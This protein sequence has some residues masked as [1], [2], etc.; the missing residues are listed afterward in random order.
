[1]DTLREAIDPSTRV[2]FAF[3]AF[4]CGP[5]AADAQAS[6]SA[7]AGVTRVV[8]D[9]CVRRAAVTFNPTQ[10]DITRIASTLSR[11]ASNPRVLSVVIQAGRQ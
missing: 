9:G 6:L 1:M 7:L 4:P 3:D 8:F 10:T 11:F 2:E 5:C